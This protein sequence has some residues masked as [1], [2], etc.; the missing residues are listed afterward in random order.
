MAKKKLIRCSILSLNKEMQI[1]HNAKPLNTHQISKDEMN[2]I[3]GNFVGQSKL[4]H[5]VMEV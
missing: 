4:S 2:P 1:N 5:V 3:L